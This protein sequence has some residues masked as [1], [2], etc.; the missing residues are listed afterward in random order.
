MNTTLAGLVDT[1]LMQMEAPAN[2]EPCSIRTGQTWFLGWILI[3][4]IIVIGKILWKLSASVLVNIHWTTTPAHSAKG[5]NKNSVFNFFPAPLW[6]DFPLLP[7][8]LI[9]ITSNNLHLTLSP[10]PFH[11]S[12]NKWKAPN[13]IIRYVVCSEYPHIFGSKKWYE[14]KSE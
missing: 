8:P 3:K 10:P 2:M 1:K 9:K 6:R 12:K 5:F 13:Q 7:Q 4:I 11:G 14:Q